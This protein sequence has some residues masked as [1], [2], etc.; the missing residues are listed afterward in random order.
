MNPVG[1]T[2]T[3]IRGAIIPPGDGSPAIRVMVRRLSTSLP[4]GQLL[5]WNQCSR[6]IKLMEMH[7]GSRVIVLLARSNTVSGASA[8][9]G[10]RHD[11]ASLVSLLRC[12]MAPH[13]TFGTQCYAQS[14]WGGLLSTATTTAAVIFV[15]GRRFARRG[16]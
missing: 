8:R 9:T 1:G 16:M 10:G 4:A 3:A 6:R 14:Q 2:I 12:Y 13:S 11:Y 5:Q 7:S 15:G